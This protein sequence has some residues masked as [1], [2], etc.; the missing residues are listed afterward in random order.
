M[1]AALDDPQCRLVLLTGEPGAGKSGLLAQLAD[2]H[3]HWP[4]Y[5][6]RRDQRAPL[7]D[8]S[9]RSFL[10]RIGFQLAAARPELL[11]ADQVRITVD[12]RIG[13]VGEDGSVVAAEVQRILGSPFHQA[14]IEVHQQ[15]EAAGGAVAGVRVGEWVADPRRLDLADLSAMAL[16]DPARVLARLDPAGQL[17]VLVDALDEL[18]GAPDAGESLTAWLDATALPGNVRVV[19][20]SR[21]DSALRR[22]ADRHGEAVREVRIDAADVRVRSDLRTYA[23]TLAAELV[24][25]GER[26]RFVADVV[27]KADGNLGYLDALGRAADRA[28]PGDLAALLSLDD[29]PGDLIALHAFFLRRLRAGPGNRSVLVED[30]ASGAMLPVEAWPAVLRPLLQTLCVAFGPLTIDQLAGL[31]GTPVRHAEVAA[32]VD[33]LSQFLDRRGDR[34]ELYHATFAEFMTAPGTRADPDTAALHVDPV[35]AHGRLAR[36]LGAGDIWAQTAGDRAE[37]QARK[38]YARDH[39]IDHLEAGA[40]WAELFATLDDPAWVRGRADLDP[41]TFALCADLDAGRR[42]A[43]RPGVTGDEALALLPRLWRYSLLRH[44]LS[45]HA[46]AYPD[47]GYLAMALTGDVDRA[48]ELAH[49]ISRPLRRVLVLTRIAAALGRADAEDD[50]VAHLIDLAVVAAAQVVDPDEQRQAGAIVL[51]S[52]GGAFSRGAGVYAS[53]LE[54]LESLMKRPSGLTDLVTWLGGLIMLLHRAG[55][56]DD[57]SRLLDDL[58]GQLNERVDDP[59]RG[60]ALAMLVGVAVDIGAESLAREAAGA[61]GHG[62]DLITAATEL[63]RSPTGKEL[64]AELLTGLAES[65]EFGSADAAAEF[66]SRMATA[67][68]AL[69]D[70]SRAAARAVAVDEIRTVPQP[71][72]PLLAGIVTML[73]VAGEQ[74]RLEEMCGWLLDVGLAS[75]HHPEPGGTTQFN[76]YAVELIT[77]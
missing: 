61:L 30:P 22:L 41:S 9:A 58:L 74:D 46:D 40:L 16:L 54:L 32:A 26:E 27:D 63:A 72:V 48:V 5:L 75:I 71:D 68:S 57:V 55:A 19:V 60:A 66:H 64:A 31:S 2:D 28:E 70:E 59:D 6:L 24:D 18:A 10:L 4:V 38:A 77:P 49:L 15:V 35:E 7:A 45:S 42:A 21:P 17:V 33:Q 25:G 69:G 29:L 65:P 56:D 50:D 44:S 39:L 37:E 62:W 13:P 20:A 53:T 8:G 23:G 36:R 47:S 51:G 76:L 1:S 67:W 52:C 34:Y 3:P 14:V 11:A 73:D 12:Q 43:A